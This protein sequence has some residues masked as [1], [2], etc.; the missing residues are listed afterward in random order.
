ME[1]NQ[2]ERP[3]TGNGKKRSR[4]DVAPTGVIVDWSA[5]LVRDTTDLSAVGTPSTDIRFPST[6][7]TIPTADQISEL[8]KLHS[9]QSCLAQ[10]NRP[11]PELP[12]SDHGG[13][14]SSL[15]TAAAAVGRIEND[16]SVSGSITGLVAE[17]F[18]RQQQANDQQ[19]FL[20]VEGGGVPGSSVVS[21]ASFADVEAVLEPP[22]ILNDPFLCSKIERGMQNSFAYLDRQDRIA[23]GLLPA[24]HS[25][26][27]N[28]KT[29]VRQMTVKPRRIASSSSTA[30]IGTGYCAQSRTSAQMAAAMDIVGG[31]KDRGPH[32]LTATAGIEH[33]ATSASTAVPH[34]TSVYVSQLPLDF[35]EGDL[36]AIFGAI[37]RIKRVKM[38]K[39]SVGELGVDSSAPIEGTCSSNLC[40]NNGD[41]LITFASHH[42]ARAAC[43][44]FNNRDFGEGYSLSVAMADWS[45]GKGGF[46]QGIATSGDGDRNIDT[47]GAPAVYAPMPAPTKDCLWTCG[48]G[49]YYCRL[50]YPMRPALSLAPA[51]YWGVVLPPQSQV[52]VLPVVILTNLHPLYR[53][54]DA[55]FSSRS[56][57][58]DML[59]E[60]QVSI[61]AV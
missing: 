18:K 2:C 37:G 57:Y 33:S 42:D 24:S 48:D 49:E 1:H 32:G 9:Q 4:F 23:S 7:N 26:S 13:R 25:G 39:K 41:A 53:A 30:G 60:L 21:Y 14:V 50:P 19:A 5:S 47:C 3:T 44:Q 58:D 46:R 36:H 11:H 40:E 17:H 52:F 45:K 34:N 59:V 51:L 55:S 6:E 38:Y 35:D 16:S 29:Q 10:S 15:S 12:G 56:A 61:G 28:K 20:S 31:N 54:I 22:I 8:I 43:L 27:G